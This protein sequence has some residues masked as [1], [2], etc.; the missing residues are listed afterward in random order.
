ME[1]KNALQIDL[2]VMNV[3]LTTCA[4]KM[5]KELLFSLFYFFFF[6]KMSFII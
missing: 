5:T 4:K 2:N 1:D 3:Q 6:R